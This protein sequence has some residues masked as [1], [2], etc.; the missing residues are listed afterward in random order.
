M[1]NNEEILF[2]SI[3]MCSRRERDFYMTSYDMS[4]IS[5]RS[6]NM[7]NIF[8]SLVIYR[9]F[10]GEIQRLT[11]KPDNLEADSRYTKILC[12]NSLILMPGSTKFQANNKWTLF[13]LCSHQYDKWQNN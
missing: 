2:P 4:S 13:S 5:Q 1:E 7:S 6:L 9:N 12:R 8:L 10:N 3:T 11:L